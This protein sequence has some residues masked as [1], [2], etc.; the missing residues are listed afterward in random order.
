[1]SLFSFI[2]SLFL[3]IILNKLSSSKYRIYKCIQSNKNKK[4]FEFIIKNF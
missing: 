1:M 4:E 3:S 2:F